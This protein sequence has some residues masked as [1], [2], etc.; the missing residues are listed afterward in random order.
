MLLAAREGTGLSVNRIYA[1]QLTIS[2]GL[3]AAPEV[4]RVRCLSQA[5]SLAI[6]LLLE[7][8]GSRVING[9]HVI[10]TC[11]DK[12]ATTAALTVAGVPAPRTGVAFSIE[13]ALELC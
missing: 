1:P 9:S 13:G 3:V 2:P 5:R 10:R 8:A 11:G 4:A 6:T 12:L 7:A